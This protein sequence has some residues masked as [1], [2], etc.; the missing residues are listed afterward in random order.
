MTV[1]PYILSNFSSIKNHK[2]AKSE[3]WAKSTYQKWYDVLIGKQ[4]EHEVSQMIASLAACQEGEV[5]IS[6]GVKEKLAELGI[7]KKDGKIKIKD[8]KNMLSWLELAIRLQIHYVNNDYR[9]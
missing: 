9:F 8:S 6:E 5:T 2:S 7:L 1:I 4:C 3:D